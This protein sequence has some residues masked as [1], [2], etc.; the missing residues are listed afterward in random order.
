MIKGVKSTREWSQ[1]SDLQ[2]GQNP[3]G[4]D[5][6]SA[7]RHRGIHISLDESKQIKRLELEGQLPL[8]LG[9]IDVV[10]EQEP[11][12]QRREHQDDRDDDG[13]PNPRR[14]SRVQSSE[15]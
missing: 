4:V 12:P 14:R 1:K 3:P 11:D 10:I 5:A 15:P 13:K 9:E 2:V 6:S 8:E 7:H